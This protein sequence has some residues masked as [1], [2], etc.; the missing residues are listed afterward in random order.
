L[1]PCGE[2]V[3]AM[4]WVSSLRRAGGGSGIEH[5]FPSSPDGIRS[6]GWRRGAELE[7]PAQPAGWAAAATSPGQPVWGQSPTAIHPVP[8]PLHA[9]NITKIWGR[10]PGNRVIDDLDLT[11]E[12]GTL[13]W[14]G[15]SNGVGKT[16]LLRVLAGLIGP[17]EGH[18][19]MFGLHPERRPACLPAAPVVPPRH[20][21]WS[22]CAP[23]RA[24]AARLHATHQ[25]RTP[26]AATR[27]GRGVDQALLADGAR[28]A[29]RRSSLDETTTDRALKPSKSKD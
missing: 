5:M 28:Q 21:H 10:K 22:P 6:R 7:G 12:P 23:H 24:Q 13:T 8:L 29:P 15:G 2:R 26:R 4:T 3:F 16:T 9:W 19:H 11:L 27:G 18:V 17:T 25:L 20:Q 14:I 1:R